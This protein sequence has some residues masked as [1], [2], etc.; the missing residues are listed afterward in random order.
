[1]VQQIKQHV[2]LAS[3]NVEA[4]KKVLEKR[5]L[6]ERERERIQKRISTCDEKITILIG[7]NGNGFSRKRG[8]KLGTKKF[9]QAPLE[10]FVLKVLSSG[11][12]LA[13]REV[14][15]RVKDEGYQTHQKSLTNFRSTIGVVLR[16]ID[17]VERVGRAKYIYTPAAVVVVKESDVVE[18]EVEVV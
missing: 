15:D 12:K 9:S 10:H 7:S 14:A 5:S 6:L 18:K 3:K 8:P 2:A 17:G 16:S 11:E 13:P 4:A 1:M